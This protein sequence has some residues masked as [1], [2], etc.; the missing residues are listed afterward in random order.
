MS[1][2]SGWLFGIGATVISFMLFL[3]SIIYFLLAK[4]PNIKIVYASVSAFITMLFYI[5]FSYMADEKQ[6]IY[7]PNRYYD[8]LGP[9]WTMAAVVIALYVFVNA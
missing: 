4:D 5:G 1:G 6:W 8:V 7:F 9:V 2:L 3:I